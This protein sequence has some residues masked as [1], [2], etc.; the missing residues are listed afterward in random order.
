[1]GKKLHHPFKPQQFAHHSMQTQIEIHEEAVLL[2]VETGKVIGIIFKERALA[3][4][5]DY[6]I[7]MLM[8]PIAMF[9]Y[10]HIAHGYPPAIVD[11]RYCQLLC[12]T[13]GRNHGAAAI[14]L[15]HKRRNI[16][17]HKRICSIQAHIERHRSQIERMGQHTFHYCI[18]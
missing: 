13:L 5:T 16:V 8:A 12:P 11:N 15:F 2:L 6:C 7:P 17:N 4:G 14:G 10:A 18:N 1:M 9:A 3:I